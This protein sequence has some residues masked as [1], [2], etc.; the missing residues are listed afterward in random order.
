[1]IALNGVLRGGNAAETFVDSILTAQGSVKQR[2][3][4]KVKGKIIP[5]L[6]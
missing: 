1:M 5:V 3:T 4:R 2:F 6:I